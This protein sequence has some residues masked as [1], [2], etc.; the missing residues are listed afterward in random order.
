MPAGHDA[1]VPP[2]GSEAICQLIVM[3]GKQQQEKSMPFASA[4]GLP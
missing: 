2:S 3:A 1:S 4:C